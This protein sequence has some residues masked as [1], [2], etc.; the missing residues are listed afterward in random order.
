[1]ASLF[2]GKVINAYY[3]SEDYN[4][5][6]VI[7]TEDDGNNYSFILEVDEESPVY[8]DLISEGYTPEKLINTTAENKR[9]QAAE[10]N[11]LVH[12]VARNMAEEMIGLGDL[13]KKKENISQEL[14]SKEKDLLSLDQEVRAARNTSGSV[15][16][17][18][19]LE[20]N[21][22][23]DEVFK[24]KLWALDLDFVKNSTK[25]DKSKLR[26]SKNIIEGLGLLSELLEKDS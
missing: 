12:S 3:I 22:Q 10:F 16:F 7:Y 26:K 24:F 17:E 23:K 1:M 5:I 4:T 6:E 9:A 13:Q 15:T 8:Q 21:N 11:Q 2:S 18:S 19:I 14:S 20:N 25:E